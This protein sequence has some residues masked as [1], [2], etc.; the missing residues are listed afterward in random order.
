MFITVYIYIYIYIFSLLINLI[1]TARTHNT[2]AAYQVVFSYFNKLINCNNVHNLTNM[3][4]KCAQ[5]VK[6]IHQF[7]TH[8]EYYQSRPS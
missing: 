2:Y 3:T 4:P 7:L 6:K 8:W 5:M 1:F